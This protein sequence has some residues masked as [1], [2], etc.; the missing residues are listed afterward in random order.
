MYHKHRNNFSNY[1]QT[2]ISL[3]RYI[4]RL[5]CPLLLRFIW[6]WLA[7]VFLIWKVLHFDFHRLTGILDWFG[8]HHSLYANS[9]IQTHGLFLSHLFQ[10][11][12]YRS[13]VRGFMPIRT[14]P[15]KFR[16][17]GITENNIGHRNLIFG[18]MVV[19]EVDN[20]CFN[21]IRRRRWE[22]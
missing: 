20:E 10:F 21:C 13:S 8:C 15:K 14:Q 12:I 3:L 17:A 22:Y 5:V 4:P 7:A 19:S 1:Q 6:V 11:S 16:Y 2:K 18:F 9:G